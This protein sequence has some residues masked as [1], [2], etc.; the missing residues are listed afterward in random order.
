VITKTDV[1][2]DEEKERHLYFITNE[3]EEREGGEEAGEKRQKASIRSPACVYVC[4]YCIPPKNR[5]KATAPQQQQ[6]QQQ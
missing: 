1:C 3:R 6:Q 2:E 4:V 5:R